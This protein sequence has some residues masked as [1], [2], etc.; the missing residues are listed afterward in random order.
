M[1]STYYSEL[2]DGLHEQA[3]AISGLDDF[4]DSYYRDNLKYLLNAYDA[5]AQ[6]SEQGRAVIA[7]TLLDCL[8]SRLLSVDGWKKN[9]QCLK[10][11][12]ESPIF[13]IGLPRTGTTALHKLLAADPDCQY[14]E[15]WLATSPMTRPPRQLWK[16]NAHYARAE[17]S[18][19]ELY[20]R[21]DGLKSA[22]HMTAETAD[23]CRFLLMQDFVGMT[24]PCNATIPD[25]ESW[26]VDTNLVPAY[27]RHRDNLCLIGANDQSK[28]WV[29]KNPGHIFALQALV[30]VYPDCKIIQTHRDPSAL[31]PSVSSLVYRVRSVNEP[32]VSKAQVGRQMLDQWAQS[33]DRC[34]EAR[35]AIEP[36]Q[37]LDIYYDDFVADAIGTARSIYSHFDLTMS[38]ETEKSL[39]SWHD[40]N[41]QGKHGVHD[42]SAQEYGLSADIIRDRFADYIR[43]FS[44]PLYDVVG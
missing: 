35:K 38:A 44:V 33:L 42:Y 24:Y 40:D 25:Y 12:I 8:V 27:Q 4:G 36:D 7:K 43:H 9:P 39:A 28:R 26:I 29:L 22:H 16:D 21:A 37:I 23:E 14:L 17:K 13:V 32:G 41:R 34:I 1:Q 3:R 5:T 10:Q 15:Y 2:F 31:I 18:L 30:A 6:L 20:A 19:Q 11:T